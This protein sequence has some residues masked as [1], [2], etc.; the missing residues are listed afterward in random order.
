MH[1]KHAF[2]VTTNLM[3]QRKHIFLSCYRKDSDGQKRLCT[4]SR[5]ILNYWR[6]LFSVWSFVFSK[7]VAPKM[8]M[9]KSC[10]K[11]FKIFCVSVRIVVTIRNLETQYTGKAGRGFSGIF[12]HT[13]KRNK[14]FLAQI[15]YVFNISW[16]ILS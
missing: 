16:N 13:D 4:H 1:A 15:L 3:T 8:I 6:Y 14:N 5:N 11:C 9:A 7:C 10:F 2:S 12:N